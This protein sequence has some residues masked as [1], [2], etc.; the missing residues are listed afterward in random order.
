VAA[1]IDWPYEV[2]PM[3]LV[4]QPQAVHLVDV[5]DGGDGGSTLCCR[6]PEA[7]LEAWTTKHSLPHCQAC[8]TRVNDPLSVY[9]RAWRRERGVD[10][11]VS[12]GLREP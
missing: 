5:Y 8:F 9:T 12:D 7:R 3:V 11:D 2:V 10:V 6:L 1:D 4:Q